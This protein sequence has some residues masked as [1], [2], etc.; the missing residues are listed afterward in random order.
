MMQG[1]F[2]IVGVGPGDPQLMTLKAAKILE[3]CDTWFVPSAFENGGSMALKIATGVVAQQGKVI[4]SHRFPMKQVHRGKS[5]DPEVKVAWQEAA[6]II[7]ECLAQGRDVV[8][9]TL[10][11]PAIY[12]TGFYVCETLQECGSPFKIEIVPGVSAIGASSAVS[13]VPLCLGD[14]RLV[15]IPATFENDRIR[16][17]LALCDAVVFMKVHKVLPRLVGL[18]EELGLVDKAVLVERCSLADQRVWTDIRQA[19][20]E[21][22]HYFSTMVVRKNV[23][24]EAAAEKLLC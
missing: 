12:S 3:K 1:T 17:L 13:T 9:P 5:P 10:G 16:E 7:M 4:L 8:F 20:G 24:A 14:E 6:K 22:L 15:V 21:E 2:Y 18:L 19:L 23:S 11:D